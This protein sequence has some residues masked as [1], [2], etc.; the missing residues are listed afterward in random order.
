MDITLLSVYGSSKYLVGSKP[1]ANLSG[2]V[3]VRKFGFGLSDL[4]RPYKVIINLL[5]CKLFY[6]RELR[7]LSMCR[8]GPRSKPKGES[9]NLL[10]DLPSEA[11]SSVIGLLQ[12]K[13][14]MT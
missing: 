12:K 1:E 3:Y 11:P 2:K 6:R 7:R 9:P 4:I 13:N 10:H 14:S 8:L 5:A